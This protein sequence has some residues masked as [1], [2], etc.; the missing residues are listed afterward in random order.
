MGS[1]AQ[2]GGVSRK[3]IVYSGYVGL[4]GAFCWVLISRE[5]LLFLLRIPDSFADF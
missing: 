1:F 3:D 5:A 2:W 4:H